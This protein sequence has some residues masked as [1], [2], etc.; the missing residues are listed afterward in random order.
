[1]RMVTRGDMDGL[2]C[3]VLI[4]QFVPIESFLLIHPQDITDRKVEIGPDDVLANVPFHPN[5]GM[6]FDHHAHSAKA[7]LP[8]E[9]FPGAWGRAPSTARLVYEHYGAWEKLLA[10]EELVRETDRMDSAELSPEEI[11][12]PQRFMRLGFTLDA[13]TGLGAFQDYVLTVF[14]LLRHRQ[15]I[16]KVLD[17]PAVRRRWHQIQ[18]GDA[19]FRQALQEHSRVDG[20]VVITDFRALDPVPVGNRF[21]IYALFPKVNVSLRLHWGPRR[22]F[23][24]AALGHSIFDRSCNTDVG[25]LAARYGGGGHRAAASVPLPVAQADELAGRIVEEL[26]RNG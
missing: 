7:E 15:A 3:A 16:E 25:E 24:V 4:S 14:D 19:N 10:F 20:N 5:C 6:W 22:Q 21:L 9:G 17:H 8:P 18:E 23:V 2:V 13:R 12:N 26:K 11:E 1:M